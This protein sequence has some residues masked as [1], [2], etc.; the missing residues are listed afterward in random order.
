MQ[1]YHFGKPIAEM[2]SASHI[3]FRHV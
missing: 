1:G 3:P 2:V